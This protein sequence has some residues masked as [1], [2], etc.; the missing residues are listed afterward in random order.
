IRGHS[1]CAGQEE[2][3]HRGE[4]DT[5]CDDSWDLSDADVV[6]RQLG[7]GAAVSAPPGA[8]YGQGSGPILLDDVG[9]TGGETVLSQCP[10]R[11]WRNHNCSHEDDA[12]VICDGSGCCKAHTFLMS[13]Y[14]SVLPRESIKFSCT[15]PSSLLTSDGFELYKGS[16]ENPTVTERASSPQTMVELTVSHGHIT[17]LKLQLSVYSQGLQ[18]DLQFPSELLRL[19]RRSGHKAVVRISVPE[20]P[21]SFQWIYR[22]QRSPLLSLLQS[23]NFSITCSIAPQYPGGSFHLLLSGSEMQSM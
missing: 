20:T 2:V 11:E 8:V 13:N 5:V 23:H 22:H 4:W 7:C 21:F 15:A 9:C 14:P 16:D 17:A 6:R 18:T 10:S 12:S 3:Y 1:S 19:C